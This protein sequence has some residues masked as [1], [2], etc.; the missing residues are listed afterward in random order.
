MGGGNGA[1]SGVIDEMTRNRVIPIWA[2]IGPGGVKEII[3]HV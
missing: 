1:V 2:K 3:M